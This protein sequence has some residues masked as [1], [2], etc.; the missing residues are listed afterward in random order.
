LPDL[1]RQVANWP[2]LSSEPRKY[3]FH[4][5][6]KAPF[7][8]TAGMDEQ[9]LRQAAWMF[10]AK[11]HAP[12]VFVPAVSALRAFIAIVPNSPSPELDRFALECVTYFDCFRAPLT[13][14]DRARRKPNA[15]SPRQRANLDRWGYPY[16]GEEFHFH[17]T[18]TDLLPTAQ[19]GHL[20]NILAALF[21][22]SVEPLITIGSLALLKQDTAQSRFHILE[23]IPF[24][25]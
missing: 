21:T 20:Q 2:Q 10:V 3:G 12:I 16:V 6:L 4:A 9:A 11:Q 15:L 22:D 23:H 24:R 18:L 13:E 25:G 19:A 8:L 17:M 1:T 5:T 14:D 7:S